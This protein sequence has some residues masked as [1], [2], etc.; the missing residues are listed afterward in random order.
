MLSVGRIT[1][2]QLGVKRSTSIKL[3]KSTR[4]SMQGQKNQNYE[5]IGI[6]F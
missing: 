1:F 4:I 5:I 6:I 2:G 3:L